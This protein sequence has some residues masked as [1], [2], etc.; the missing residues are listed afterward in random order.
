MQ[1]AAPGA[2]WILGL[3]PLILII[4][5]L[6]PKPR[7]VEI[8]GLFLWQ[9]AVNETSSGLHIRQMIR[10][11]L[12]LF[13]QI[14]IIVLSALGMAGPKWLYSSQKPD[15]IILITDVSASMKTVTPEGTRF[16]QAK[17]KAIQL[18]D[19]LRK[20]SKMLIIEAGNK[21][22]LKSP[23]SDDKQ[24]LKQII[25][26]MQPQ[27]VPGKLEKALY[28][29][30]S[31]AESGRND[32][33]CL[34]TDG[35]GIKFDKIS[36]MYKNIKLIFISGGTRN[37][38]ITRFEF[39]QELIN[40]DQYQILLEIKNFNQAE[41]VCPV[42]LSVDETVILKKTVRLGPMEKKQLIFPYGGLI[43]GIAQA[44]LEIT[45]DFPVDNQAHT[46]LNKSKDIWVLLV[47]KGNY[48]LEKI[49]SAYPNIKI[50]RI[51]EIIP[52]SW[53]TQV[54]S[55]DIVILDRITS[56]PEVNAGSF[57]L[58]KSF[59]PSIPIKAKG[60]IDNPTV[61]DWDRNHPLTDN[62]DLVRLSIRSAVLADTGESARVLVESG[63]TGLMHVYQQSKLRAVFL[64]FDPSD[65]D[66]PLRVAFPVMMSNIFNWLYPN[67]LRFSSLQTKTGEIFPI[68]L[69]TGTRKFKIRRPSGKWETH[70]SDSNIFE[71]AD[72]GE[73][74]IYTVAEGKKWRYFAVNLTDESESD[75]IAKKYKSPV[76][77]ADLNTDT[78][79]QSE[80]SFRVLF[81]LAVAGILIFEWYAWL[82]KRNSP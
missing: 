77:K 24:R 75:I 81:F 7:Q 46:V 51:N 72:T 80:L 79:T 26:D 59:S 32:Q 14:F 44:S 13:L 64:G 73:A 8:A 28:M 57:I 47:S 36:G 55:N 40:K 29:A 11:N 31:F 70:Y 49:L 45:D 3:I 20:E 17:K 25:A 62:L 12:P 41:T 71:Y 53:T 21:P 27:D 76:V 10:K 18:A 54:M 23:F 5:S 15:R 35:A 50:S 52:S 34:I 67:K 43:A 2:L 6:R 30:L 78:I 19:S 74:G 39:R 56:F 22:I 1:F 33:I 58:I 63:E 4:H 68:Y 37:T 61:L 82:G 69:K 42:S 65:S 9:D 48:Y 16:E 38:G 66:L 60:R